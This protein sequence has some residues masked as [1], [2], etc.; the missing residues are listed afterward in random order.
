VLELEERRNALWVLI[1]GCC[2]NFACCFAFTLRFFVS[3]YG[4]PMTFGLDRHTLFCFVGFCFFVPPLPV[5]LFC[6]FYAITSSCSPILN[7]ES[8]VNFYLKLSCFPFS[9]FLLPLFHDIVARLM[10]SA[11]HAHVTETIMS[12]HTQTCAHLPPY[13]RKCLLCGC[14]FPMTKRSDTHSANACRIEKLL[15]VIPLSKALIADAS[16]VEACASRGEHAFTIAC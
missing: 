1:L 5:F 9:P 12:Y 2:H 8:F 11:F 4:W 14:S 6:D 3:E 16:V 15:T 7:P 10:P 13:D